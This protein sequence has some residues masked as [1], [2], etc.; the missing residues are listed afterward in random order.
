MTRIQWSI[1]MSWPLYQFLTVVLLLSYHVPG[2]PAHAPYIRVSRESNIGIRIPDLECCFLNWKFLM[3]K[4]KLFYTLN[5]TSSIV[6][7][8]ELNSDRPV[9]LSIDISKKIF[10]S[11][12][13]NQL[14]PW[15]INST[16][17]DFKTKSI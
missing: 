10:P 3:L 13:P 16:T 9:F 4:S 2:I 17:I 15:L 6:L 5:S 8:I 12:E 14:E 1:S 11:L 7:Q